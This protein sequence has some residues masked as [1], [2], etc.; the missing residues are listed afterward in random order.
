THIE[1]KHPQ[2]TVHF[3]R[4]AAPRVT[5]LAH[6]SDRCQ[7]SLYET[8]DRSE[9][10]PPH[11]LGDRIAAQLS[12]SAFYVPA[13]FQLRQNLLQKFY[14]KFLLYRQFARL[15]NWKAQLLCDPKINYRS[16][17]ILAAFRKFHV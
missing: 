2:T 7:R 13:Q 8:D 11:W 1:H 16:E 17:C 6:T 10:D 14:W 5:R 4:T 3:V 15:Q 9:L 12:A